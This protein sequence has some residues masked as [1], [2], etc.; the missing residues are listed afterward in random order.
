MCFVACW[1]ACARDEFHHITW[2]IVHLHVQ[3]LV[4]LGIFHQSICIYRKQLNLSVSDAI[5]CSTKLPNNNF[6]NYRVH[7]PICC[8]I[9]EKGVKTEPKEGNVREQD[10]FV[11]VLIAAVNF[12]YM[13]WCDGSHFHVDRLVLAGN[14]HHR[15]CNNQK[16]MYASIHLKQNFMVLHREFVCCVTFC[17]WPFNTLSLS[18]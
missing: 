16:F 12:I 17:G 15:H 14:Q 4:F 10:T 7:F 18:V 13:K 11:Q 3:N 8:S 6:Q 5:K 9:S 2:N 1:W